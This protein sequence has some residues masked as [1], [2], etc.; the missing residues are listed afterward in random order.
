MDT[1]MSYLET[2]FAKLPKTQEIERVKQDLQLNMEEKYQELIAEGKTENEAVGTVISEFGNIDELMEELGYDLNEEEEAQRSL[3]DQEIGEFLLESKHNAK[4]VGS[5]VALILLGVAIFMLIIGFI[6]NSDVESNL[7]NISGLIPLLIF[8]AVAVG[9]FIV[10]DHRME[11]YKNIF[12]EY[13]LTPTQKQRVEHEAFDR[14]PTQ[15]RAIVIGVVLCIL[16]PLCLIIISVINE[17]YATFGVSILLVLIAIAI[18]LF[19]Y[20]GQQKS[21]YEQLLEN[22]EYNCEA[23]DKEDKVVSAVAAVIWPLATAIFLITGLVFNY[24]HINWIIFPVT[25]LLFAGFSGFR[26][27]MKEK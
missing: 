23:K 18:Y 17:S 12:Q 14:R 16:A 19:I 3:T 11:P 21:T 4:M 24:W 6:S 5:G 7:L 25:G 15:L 8:V 2:M 9:M 27:A 1:I 20:Y 13:Q 26:S 10:A 22:K